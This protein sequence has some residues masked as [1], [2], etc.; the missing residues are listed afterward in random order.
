MATMVYTPEGK[1]ISEQLWKE[2]MIEFSFVDAESILKSLL[3]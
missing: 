2:T 1:R 3:A